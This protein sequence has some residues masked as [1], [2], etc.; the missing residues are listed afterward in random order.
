ME[1]KDIPPEDTKVAG[2]TEENSGV[3]RSAGCVNATQENPQLLLL[4]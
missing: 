1:D 3:A 4:G 2:D